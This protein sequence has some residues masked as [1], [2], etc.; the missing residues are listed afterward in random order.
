MAA[1]VIGT[2]SSQSSDSPHDVLD[3]DVASRDTAAAC[4][5]LSLRCGVL[6]KAKGWR[7]EEGRAQFS[8]EFFCYNLL[9]ITI[10][11]YSSLRLGWF[12]TLQ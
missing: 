2:K 11:L 3:L 4:G 12:G 8:S 5:T 10:Y 7:S 9:P 6:H 1:R